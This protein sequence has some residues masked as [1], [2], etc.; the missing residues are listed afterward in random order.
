MRRLGVC[1]SA[2]LLFALL[3][4]LPAGA[5][6][7]GKSPPYV[8]ERDKPKQLSQG[9]DGKAG[10]HYS[11]RFTVSLAGKG[12]QK[13]D[14][15]YI[16]VIE[17]NGKKV[18]E[19]KLPRPTETADLSAILAVD[20]SG[21]MAKHDR[22]PLARRATKA[23]LDK[24]PPPVECGLVLF[25][26]EIR[27]PTLPPMLD[28]QPIAD[29]VNK[30][31]PRGGTAYR[32]AAFKALEMLATIPKG[33][34]RALV[35][36]TDGADVNSTYHSLDD[37]IAEAKR[38]EAK[39]YT[40]G[41][42]EPGKEEKVNT[43]LVLDHSGSMALPADDADPNTPKISG[44]HDAGD[45]FVNMMPERTGRVSLVPFSS[46]VGAPR[47]FTNNREKLKSH[48]RSLKPEGE[49]ALVDAVYTGIATLEA[50]AAP[51]KRAV[52]AM[53]DG[54][55]NSSRRRVEE[56][57]A[58][59]KD[60]NIKLYLLGFGRK[61]EIDE[62]TMKRMAD[63]TGGK[64]YH[65]PNKA[66]LMEIFENLS[67]E[68]HDDGIDETSLKRIA[69]ETGGSYHHARDVSSLELIL[70]GISVSLKSEAYE[71]E[72]PSLNP[73]AD[74][75]LSTIGLRLVRAGSSTD[76]G[77]EV[78]IDVMQR[79]GLIVAEMHP[80]TYFLLLAVLACLIA[81]PAALKRSAA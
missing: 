77:T 33:R 36:M 42:G 50:D 44:L 18:A 53:T 47:A 11:V 75:G 12:R 43:T 37:I 25:D 6:S 57:I 61:S 38:Q 66:A 19:R 9:S 73:R 4:S 59:A 28:R 23:F 72:F 5:Q 55:D 78:G 54:I 35:L 30:I 16:V 7:D 56:V 22:M 62:A 48:I 67:I 46:Q 58:R 29:A 17:E 20:T 76:E 34:D 39:I 15:D 74:G 65:A 60:A 49:T 14:G 32:D 68:L 27:Q 10:I 3:L 81:A 69:A 71:V 31:E 26:H 24:L 70:T 52:I 40:I 45:A 79:H 8:I 13:V 51:G 80:L 21:S 41:I 1:I 2:L 63:E 64:Y